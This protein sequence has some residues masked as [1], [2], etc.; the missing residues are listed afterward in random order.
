MYIVTNTYKIEINT[1][2][3]INIVQFKN[4]MP[5]FIFYKLILQFILLHLFN[6]LNDVL[7]FI[8]L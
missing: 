8:T 6:K 5:I 3:K 4:I 1:E 7:L 2:E